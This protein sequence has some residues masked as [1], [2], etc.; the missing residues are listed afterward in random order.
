MLARAHSCA[1]A[2]LWDAFPPSLIELHCYVVF[3]LVDLSLTCNLHRIGATAPLP[4]RNAILLYSLVFVL[5]P[6]T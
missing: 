6:G 5:R 3:S 4:P 2:E 1:V